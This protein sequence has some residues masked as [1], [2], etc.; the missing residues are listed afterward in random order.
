MTRM[1]KRL[2]ATV[3]AFVLPVGIASYAAGA[4]A[5]TEKLHN[6]VPTASAV[7]LDATTAKLDTLPVPAK[8]SSDSVYVR[9]SDGYV[10]SRGNIW[11]GT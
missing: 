4:T 7:D 9:N 6:S 11:K 10:Q 1:N 5:A 3:L 8:V 2:T